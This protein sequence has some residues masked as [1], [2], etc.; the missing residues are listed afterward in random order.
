MAERTVITSAIFKE[1]EFWNKTL[2]PLAVNL[3]NAFH[4]AACKLLLSE[5]RGLSGNGELERAL[6]LLDKLS[7]AYY[8]WERFAY[9]KAYQIVEHLPHGTF[10]LQWKIKNTVLRDNR[11]LLSRLK[12]GDPPSI[13]ADLFTRAKRRGEEK[14]Y[15]EAQLYLREALDYGQVLGYKREKLELSHHNLTLEGEVSLKENLGKMEA[16]FSRR[17]PGFLRLVEMARFP[18]I[19]LEV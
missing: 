16:I 3:F 8:H 13:I 9:E 11:L 10:L 12:E 7:S 4:Y 1:D 18:R 2:L 14:K 15:S 5:V 19:K 17:I 6:E